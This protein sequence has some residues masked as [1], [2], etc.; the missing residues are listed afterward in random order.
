M[1]VILTENF[2]SLGYVGDKVSVKPGYARNFLLPRGVA[3]E[4]FSHNAKML[5]HRLAGVNAKRARLKN[6]A[7]EVAK[8]FDGLTLEYTLKIGGEGRSFGSITTRDIEASL[9]EKGLE[10]D[11]KQIRL[12]DVIKRAG[13]YTASIKLHAEVVLEVVVRVIQEAPP[14]AAKAEGEEGGKR[15]RGSKKKAADEGGVEAATAETPAA[16]DAAEATEE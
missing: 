5:N 2:P 8:Q 6:Q 12:S 15:R 9:K 4:A 1:E 7:G 11:R 14:K 16:S 13:E 10:V 3:I